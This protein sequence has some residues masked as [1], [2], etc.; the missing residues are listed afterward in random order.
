[1]NLALLY[2]KPRLPFG[3]AGD[4]VDTGAG[5][6]VVSDVTMGAGAVEVRVL[7]GTGG[8]GGGARVAPL[9]LRVWLGIATGF[10]VGTGEGWLAAALTAFGGCGT[11][12]R[13]VAPGRG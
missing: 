6:A 4:D 11:V 9:E 1:M 12:L 7:V 5:E 2:S 13:A 8:G 3:C 10:G